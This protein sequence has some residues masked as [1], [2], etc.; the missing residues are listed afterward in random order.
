[1]E[2]NLMY[3]LIAVLVIVVIGGA[4]LL[5]AGKGGTPPAG[6]TPTPA[7][8]HTPTPIHTPAGA[9]CATVADCPPGAAR[10]LNGMC[11][12]LDEHG[13]IPSAGFVWCEPKHRCLRPSI[14]N[15]T[16]ASP[17]P[18][19][20][21]LPNPASEYCA[22]LN[23]TLEGSDCVFPPSNCGPEGGNCINA[24]VTRC[25]Q[26]AFFRGRCGK[27]FSFCAKSG[28]T[29]EN[30]TSDMG[31]WTTEYAV[32]V[33]NDSSECLEQAYLAG[34]CRQGQCLRWDQTVGGCVA[35]G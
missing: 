30:R 10:C 9:Q 34:T 26:W 21:G 16:G 23:Y 24:T 25:E 4:M 17:T 32:C 33:F 6:P 19:G 5:M 12:S 15:C 1:M 29:L 2:K 3:G 11:T 7:P 22:D 31:G 20:G 8:G 18:F 13:C 27:E 28:F 14:E 35:G